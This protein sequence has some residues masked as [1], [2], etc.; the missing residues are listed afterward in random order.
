MPTISTQIE[1]GAP[2]QRVW[3]VLTDFPGHQE[4][5]PFFVRLEGTPRL[6][7]TLTVTIAPP[8]GKRMDFRPRVVE[9][10]AP[11]RF[12]WLGRLLVPG[13]FDGRHRFELTATPDGGTM[14]HH[15]ERFSGI[16]TPFGGGMLSRTATGFETFND[17]LKKR[18]ER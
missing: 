7:E 8:G 12:A 3:D 16:L 15:G 10:D 14:L 13:I 17:A 18:C 2:P 1:I 11:H 4:W 5:D 6:G 9:L